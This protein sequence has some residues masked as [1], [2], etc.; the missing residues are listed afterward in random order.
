M[1]TVTPNHFAYAAL[2]LWP[3]VSVGL[4]MTRPLREALLWTVIGGHLLLPVGTEIKFPG[5]PAFDKNSIPA[6][7]ALL[8]CLA[9]APRASGSNLR[10]GLAEVLL[11]ALLV[12][13]FITSEF[14]SDNLVF[15]P[16]LLPG[17][18]HY[19]ALSASVAQL[20]ILIPFMLGRRYLRR[21][22]DNRAILRALTLAGLLYTLPMLLEVRLSPQLHNW[23]YGYF[24]HSFEQQ[25]RDGGFRP[26]VFLGHGLR[27]AFFGMIAILASVAL[28]KT[29]DRVLPLAPSIVTGWLGLTVLLCKS[30]GSFIYAVVLAPV[31]MFMRPRAQIRLA[32]ALVILAV[33]Y[34]LLRA[35]DLFPTEGLLSVAQVVSVKREASLKTRFDQEKMLLDRASERPWFGWGRFGRSRIYDA[36]GKDITLSDGQWVI[37]MGSFGLWGFLAEF[38]LLGLT[39]LQAL[40]A[41]QYSKSLREQVFLAALALIVAVGLVDLLPNATINPTSWLFAGALLGRADMLIRVRSKA[42]ARK[43]GT[44]QVM[45]P[46]IQGNGLQIG[47]QSVQPSSGPFER[48]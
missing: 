48:G 35:V 28:W 3:L 8:G 4:F 15:G 46:H 25:V 29:R 45:R 43:L 23:V 24:P 37:T 39:V 30:L 32:A 9:S 22:E 34:P 36:N 5:V 20:I 12:G 27:V 7:A 42:G 38:G 41:V 21:L 2:I 40:R 33:T 1:I 10:F 18:G 47:A 14:N 44:S 11:I 19:E 6:L 17:V 16:R 31:I 13:P 26:V